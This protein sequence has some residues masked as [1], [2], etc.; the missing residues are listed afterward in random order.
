MALFEI[1]TITKFE[2]VYLVEAESHE[3][4][5]ANVMD[6]DSS[7]DFFQ[8]HLGEV[9]QPGVQLTTI[10]ATYE[11]IIAAEESLRARGYF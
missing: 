10:E 8:K 3:E 6:S 4:A 2:N 7:P 1:H 11:E 5:V 9:P